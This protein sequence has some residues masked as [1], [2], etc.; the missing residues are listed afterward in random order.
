MATQPDRQKVLFVSLV[1]SFV[2]NTWIHLGK[3][4]HPMTQKIAVNL[5]EAAN[6][7]DFLEMIKQKTNGN[8]DAD[9]NRL[10][11]HAITELKMNFL[12][13]KVKSEKPSSTPEKPDTSTAP[14][15]ASSD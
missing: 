14:P 6:S 12:E 2:T 11:E 4:K 1:Q 13:E 3:V 7:I 9:E 15:Q 5:A 10:L 8:L